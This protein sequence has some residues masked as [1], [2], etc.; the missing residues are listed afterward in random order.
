MEDPEEFAV[1]PEYDDFSADDYK[2]LTKTTATYG[3]YKPKYGKFISFLK[4]FHYK[5]RTN[6][7]LQY[8]FN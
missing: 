2:P 4:T 5:Q 1:Y 3:V 7:I 8:F 6:S